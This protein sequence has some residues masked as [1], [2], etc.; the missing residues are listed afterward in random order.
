MHTFNHSVRLLGLVISTVV[1]ATAAQQ[2]IAQDGSAG[3][4]EIIVTA[5]RVEASL[6]D[7]PISLSAFDTKTIEALGVVESGDIAVYTPNLQMQKTPASQNAYGMGIRGVSSG[8][9]S[10]AVDPTVGIYVDGVYLGRSSAAAFE[11]VDLERIEVLR[12]PQ[13]TLYG[14][15][16]TGGAVNIVT[17][18]PAAE[19]GF[20]QQ[21]TVGERDLLRS[22]TSLDTGTF[23]DFS[24][25]VSFIHGERGGLAKS[26]INGGELGQY[27]QQAW[28][29]AL[30]WTPTDRITADYAF[31]HYQQ[32][33]NTDLTQI[34]F[35][36]PMQLFLGGPYYESMAAQASSH[37]RGHLP[38]AH[39][40][41]DQRLEIDGH[42]LTLDFDLGA[43]T[44]KSITA[45]R[46]FDNTYDRQAFTDYAA[47]G[48][49][50]LGPDFDGNLVPAGT[51]VTA[52]TSAGFNKHKQWSQEFQFVGRLLD[53]RFGYNTGVYYFHEEGRQFDPQFFV[54]PALLAFGELD[55]GY[56]DYLCAGDCFGKSVVL[57]S[58]SDYEY[59]AESNAWA[60]YGQFDYR[61][62]ER[63]TAIVGLRY[64]VDRKKAK[65][66]NDFDDVGHATLSGHD[67][68]NH[69][70]PSFTLTYDW[71]DAVMVY[72]KYT[73][74][75]R[76][77]GYNTRASTSTSFLKPVDEETVDSW[78]IG[79]KSQWFDNRLR[80]NGA[81][82][83]YE[84]DDRQVQQF[85]AGT[86]GASS[87]IVNAGSSEAKGL[88][89]E[90]T[91]APIDEL[92]LMLNYGYVD[93]KYKR[94]VTS[95]NDLVTGFPEFDANGEALV[96]DIAGSVSKIYGSPKHQGAVI[97]QYT[98]PHTAFGTFV[99]QV[100]ATYASAR[101]FDGQMTRYTRSDSY[102]LWNARLTLRDIPVPHGDLSVALWGRN[103]GNRAVREWGIDFGALGY[104]TNTYR[105]L[106]SVGVDLSYVY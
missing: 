12:G 20:K 42:A 93:V 1:A 54:F 43:A 32:D 80:L 71:S 23:G 30:R 8:E 56:Q 65:L 55:P 97:A 15:N 21:I 18:K 41:K 33:S 39:H 94:F 38:Y 25:K 13:G 46:K 68:W 81:L 76:A 89:I 101:D 73:T 66:R 67:S 6:Q 100:D 40:D 36:R 34:S 14:R 27:D 49:S 58:A 11:V 62:T 22:A 72:A 103:L 83:Y 16:T 57:S 2:V 78:E 7:T 60:V 74:G 104:A 70:N 26:S 79:G 4:E 10:L 85:E 24:A 37:R 59:W 77:G 29:F 82:F 63:L 91:A 75:Y 28:R 3:L 99:A 61:L 69:F 86:G 90:L 105:E 9:P 96:T 52:F 102:S 87:K 5:E 53:D 45:W 106:R 31:D 84:Y 50:L 44:L 48:A 64:S 92:L 35:V 95:V 88:E 51:N 19:F 17:A 98:F 47:D